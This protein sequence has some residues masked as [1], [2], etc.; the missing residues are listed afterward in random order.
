MNHTIVKTFRLLS[1]TLG[2]VALS[3]RL[4]G[5][6]GLLLYEPF[7]YQEGTSLGTNY[8][9]LRSVLSGTSDTVFV[10]AHRG[11]HIIVGNGN[12]AAE[13]SMS[14]LRLAIQNKIDMMECD[15]RPTSDGVLVLMHDATVDRTTNGTGTLSAMPYSEVRKLKL[16]KYGSSTL[17]TDTVPTLDQ[18]LKEARGQIYL[19]LDIDQKSDAA[20]VLAAVKNARMT[21]NVMFFVSARSDAAYLLNNGGMPMP[22]CYSVS[23]YN[24][25]IKNN[26]KPYIFQ[27]DNAGVNEEWVSMK[28]GGMKI[29]TNNYL[30]TS[31]DPVTDAWSELETALASGVNFVQTDY[32]VEMINY[33]KTKNKH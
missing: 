21:D 2:L 23:S 8:R 15:I 31:T 16:K 27:T 9:T 1:L 26:V 29:Y 12:Y 24:T 33:L 3:T 7:K 10:V 14:A 20:A 11:L 25:Y 5:Q 30:L 19:N 18:I 22:S 32:P 4:S 17:T 13:N 28:N 6:S